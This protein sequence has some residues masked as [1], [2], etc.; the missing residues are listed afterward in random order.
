GHPG[1]AGIRYKGAT[2]VGGPRIEDP[3][4]PAAGG[5]VEVLAGRPDTPDPVD[6]EEPVVAGP[7]AVGVDVP[8]PGGGE[9]RPRID[10]AGRHLVTAERVVVDLDPFGGGGRGPER[11]EVAGRAE[12][13][14]H[15]VPAAQYPRQLPQG[16][17]QRS[18]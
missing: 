9:D 10:L 2:P 12:L 15:T 16:R 11:L 5:G 14:R 6:P 18:L 1:G 8:L 7:V 4:E 17:G 13:D 3:R